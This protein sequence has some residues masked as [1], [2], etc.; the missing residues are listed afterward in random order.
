MAA[1]VAV[2]LPV[3]ASWRAVEFKGINVAVIALLAFLSLC[4]SPGTLAAIIGI[5]IYYCYARKL[6]HGLLYVLLSIV[7]A[8]GFAAG[9]ILITGN[10]VNDFVLLGRQFE[11]LRLTGGIITDS[12]PG[13]VGRFGMWVTAAWY[14]VHDW[15]ALV[16][17]FG[18]G[19]GWGKP[20]PLHSEYVSMWFQFG[21]VGIGILI[22]YIVR[23][24]KFLW[25]SGDSVLLSAFAIICL[26]MV[27]NFPVEVASTAFLIIIVCGLIERDRIAWV[28][29]H[30]RPKGICVSVLDRLYLY[31]DRSLM[32]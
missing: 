8:V 17:G 7:S 11:E 23:T 13:D 6:K 28:E 15:F 26:D 9:Y 29:L 24:A 25:E 30:P 14:L 4:L 32:H 22:S 21:I 20:Y 27:G 10:H 2:S 12:S 18:P 31:P 16:F 19:A 1:F 3:F 5:A